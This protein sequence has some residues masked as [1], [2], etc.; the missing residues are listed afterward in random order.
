M[1]R[2]IGQL[3]GSPSNSAATGGNHGTGN[4]P[5]TTPS[6]AKSPT[7]RNGGRSPSAVGGGGAWAAGSSVASAIGSSGSRHEGS[8]SKHLRSTSPSQGRNQPSQS[9]HH[10]QA[11]HASSFS[12]SH[13][14]YPNG[15]DAVLETPN[16]SIKEIST[17][18]QRYGLSAEGRQRWYPHLPD[19]CNTGIDAW[20]ATLLM[21]NGSM[22]GS[23][24]NGA[25]ATR[26]MEKQYRDA[27][28]RLT[29]GLTQYGA[30]Q[31]GGALS[32]SD[33][34]AAGLDKMGLIVALLQSEGY[35][36]SASTHRSSFQD[37]GSDG[38]G[39]R[40]ILP[41]IAPLLYRL[42]LTV[43]STNQVFHMMTQILNTGAHDQDNSSHS[44]SVT[45]P[46]NYLNVTSVLEYRALVSVFRALLRKLLPQS[47]IVLLS[48]I[49][50]LCDFYLHRIFVGI[51]FDVFAQKDSHTHARHGKHSHHQHVHT[52]DQLAHK[53]LDCYLLEGET[54]LL[55]FGYAVI[56]YFTANT[57][58]TINVIP[59]NANE[60]DAQIRSKRRF[61]SG[62]DFWSYVYHA[63]ARVT[64]EELAAVAYNTNSE[65]TP[66]RSLKRMLTSTFNI[67]FSASYFSPQTVNGLKSE[68]KALLVQQQ[69]EQQQQGDEG[70]DSLA[71]ETAAYMAGVCT[72]SVTHSKFDY[73]MLMQS[74]VLNNAQAIKLCTFMRQGTIRAFLF[75]HIR[76]LIGFN[77][78][79]CTCAVRA[80]PSSFHMAFRSVVDGC[81]LRRLLECSGLQYPCVL[82]LR[83]AM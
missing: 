14:Q 11:N 23:V 38:G 55:R 79:F 75:I 1:K 47:V 64:F 39:G 56:S 49:D 58:T 30:V 40:N 59:A 37:D 80:T 19:I 72:Q 32:A 42:C 17:M 54:C 18:I 77:I 46:G 78:Y 22:R 67:A 45:G 71:A 68:A 28:Y 65:L 57:D 29:L 81:S 63:S 76:A 34:P 82:L 25:N 70:M 33:A 48:S 8:S 52:N 53:I 9:P 5:T 20:R 21:G 41:F 4:S 15:Y 61:E 2:A 43:P 50:A 73:S 69:R 16:L 31:L 62:A 10:Q 51:F 26:I 13:Q 27:M 24:I 6:R 35:I 36:T 12:Y 3:L 44:D 66:K 60:E 74:L 83:A 7:G